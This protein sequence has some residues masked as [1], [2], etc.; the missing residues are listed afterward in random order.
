MNDYMNTVLEEERKKLPSCGRR[1]GVGHLPGGGEEESA[2]FLGEERRSGPPSW[3]RR[4]GVGLLSGG[5]EEEWASFL[6]EE[7]FHFVC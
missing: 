6:G 3:G 2:S 7:E 5:G 4:G 1:G